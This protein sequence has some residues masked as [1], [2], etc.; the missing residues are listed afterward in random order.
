MPPCIIL[1]MPTVFGREGSSDRQRCIMAFLEGL[2]CYWSPSSVYKPPG[3]WYLT[4]GSICSGFLVRMESS[5][6]PGASGTSFVDSNRELSKGTVISLSIWSRC[7]VGRHLAPW[8]WECAFKCVY[9]RSNE[10]AR[11][12]W[13]SLTD[14]LPTKAVKVI[15]ACI[16]GYVA[17]HIVVFAYVPLWNW[18]W[19][20]DSLCQSEAAQCTRRSLAHYVRGERSRLLSFAILSTL[21]MVK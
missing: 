16:V 4:C 3:C 2:G 7:G 19:W 9:T 14:P 6:L 13:W 18:P 11:M 20:E 1:S 17:L 10:R 8:K 12:M 21:R 15:S 5:V